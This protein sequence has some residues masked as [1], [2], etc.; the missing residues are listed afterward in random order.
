MVG[1][2]GHADEEVEVA[3]LMKVR[4]WRWDGNPAHSGGT[5]CEGR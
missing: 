5:I 2:S 1:N 3:A 4:D